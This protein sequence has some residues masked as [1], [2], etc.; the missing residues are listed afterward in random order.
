MHVREDL[1]ASPPSRTAHL[2]VSADLVYFEYPRGGGVFSVGSIAWF[3]SLSYNAY[4]NNVSKITEN[5]L[6]RF[7]SDD[8]L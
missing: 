8:P 3:G 7:A 5:V 1:Y 6:K 4:D 2:N